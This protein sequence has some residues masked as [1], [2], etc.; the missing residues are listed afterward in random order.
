MNVPFTDWVLLDPWFLLAIPLLLL[1]G[2]WQRR[3][4]AAAMATAAASLFAGLAPT[5]RQRLAWLPLATKLAAGLCLAFALARPVVREVMPMQ[6]QGIDILLVVDLSSSM[7]I[8][9]MS[10]DGSLR[11]MDAARRRAEEFAKART[12]DRVG[13]VVF[14]RYAELRCPP[15]LDETS[16][17]A[18]LRSL[19]TV[20]PDSGLDGTAIGAGLAKACSVLQRS[21]AKAKVVVLL[22]DGENNVDEIAPQD[23][24]KLA[25]DHGIRVHTIGLG[26]GD[27]LPFGGF[28]KL[29]FT[30][31]RGIAEQTGGTFFQPRSDQDLAA[32]YAQIDALEKS[33]LADPR[34][35]LVD[36]FHRPLALGLAGLLLALLLETLWLRRVP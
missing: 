10:K 18:F 5:L 17:A 31:L 25:K 11:R 35:R 26:M 27:P 21:D 33:E 15:T 16:L 30:A 6:E 9:D 28:R 14:A 4:P 7:Q 8:D 1:A 3:R 19:D 22:S 13:C 24:A 20:Q 23:A 36:Q 12:Q 32:V 34:Y 2:L 29:E